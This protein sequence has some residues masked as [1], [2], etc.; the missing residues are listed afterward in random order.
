MQYLSICSLFFKLFFS[1]FC[2]FCKISPLTFLAW[3]APSQH[4]CHPHHPT[5]NKNISTFQFNK[6]SSQIHF[7]F[8]V[9]GTSIVYLLNASS[10]SIY[11]FTLS[12]EQSPV[13]ISLTA[14]ILTWRQNILIV[15][16]YMDGI[17][18]ICGDLNVLF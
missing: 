6:L 9:S 8:K 18:I 7:N 14:P 3:Q 12:R 11:L 2:I 1:S 16:M 17:M 15:C 4:C 13:N 10:L 5:N